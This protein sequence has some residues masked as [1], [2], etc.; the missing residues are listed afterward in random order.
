[1]IKNKVTLPLQD[2][3]NMGLDRFY[4]KNSSRIGTHR[5]EVQNSQREEELSIFDEQ[6]LEDEE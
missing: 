3:S 1:M 5:G 2:L 6:H 4:N